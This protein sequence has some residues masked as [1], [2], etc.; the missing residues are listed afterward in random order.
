MKK[1]RRDFL[2]SAAAGGALVAAPFSL[3][4][5]E[6]HLKESDEAVGMLYDSTLCVGCKACVTKCKQVNDM[7]A[8]PSPSDEDRIWDSPEDLDYRTRNIIKLYKD[9]E[10]EANWDYVKYQCMHCIKPS[11]VSAC[12][13][14]AMEQEKERG[15]VFYDKNKCIGCRYCQ[16]A[17]PFNIPK[18]G[19]P[20][21]FPK[22]VKCDLCKYTNLKVKG[23]PACVETC[24]T[25]AVIYGKRKDLL[26]EAKRRLVT[27]PEKYTGE[28]Y[29]EY[30]VGG[31]N[32]LY[33]AGT[34]FSNLGF[35]ELEKESAAVRSEH[36]QH[37]LYKGFIAP[38]ALYGFLA[39]VAL[40]NRKTAQQVEK[41]HVIEKEI[42]TELKH[43]DE[44][45]DK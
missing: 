16:I 23:E 45:G 29:G 3:H 42:E 24:P 44:G 31:T 8:V 35:P 39:M 18:F 37:T 28:I 30:E 1:T 12:P 2:K 38:V 19:W 26:A 4:A 36:I 21:T 17:C 10:N 25:Q 32:V 22:I 27:S 5:E 15:I 20:E 9:K 41:E 6:E 40:K 34:D 13:V 7:E 33:L 14:S 43:E 11:C